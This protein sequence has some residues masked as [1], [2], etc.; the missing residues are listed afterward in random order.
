MPHNLYLH[1]A[2]VR[3]RKVDR[4]RPSKVRDANV[5][6]AIES[7]IAL[8]ISF[9]I[10]GFIVSVFASAFHAQYAAAPADFPPI[11]LSVAGHRLGEL[12]G[13]AALYIWAIGLLAA[14]QSSTMTGTY[15]GQF[16]M[17]GFLQLR[18]RPWLRV[19]IT[20]SLAIVP[21]VLVAIYVEG[22]LDPL[23]SWLNVLQSVQLPFALIPVL[24]VRER[25]QSSFT[26]FLFFP[27]FCSSFL[28]LTRMAHCRALS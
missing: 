18:V 12:F 13:P 23:D 16:V 25:R 8:F 2:L 15:A 1:S 17:Q 14:G 10:N 11:G 26:F 19:F 9:I 24:K 28:S 7:A 22:D 21:S 6:F 5:Y 27:F 3:S 4:S 20:R